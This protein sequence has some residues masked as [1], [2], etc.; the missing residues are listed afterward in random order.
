MATLRRLSLLALG[1]ALLHLIFGAIVRI[2][3]AGMGCGDHWP[4]CHGQWFPSMSDPLLVIEW[5]HRLLAALLIASLVALALAAW[6]RR[7]D[8][9]VGGRGG[10]LRAAGTALGLVVTTAAFGAVTVKL[11]N[12]P[13]ATV[14]HWG[15]AAATLAALAAAV[16]RAGGLGGAAA[17]SA[18]V[19]AKAY[20][21]AAAGVALALLVVLLGGLTAKVPGANIA[22]IGFPHCRETAMGGAPLHLQLTHRVLAFLLIF[23]VIGLF[24]A[25]RKRGELGGAPG[26]AAKVLLALVLAQLL[27]AAG[28]VESGLPPVVRSLHQAL[29]VLIW[30]AMFTLAYLSRIA[31]GIGAAA[32]VGGQPWGPPPERHDNAAASASRHGGARPH[33]A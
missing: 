24:M 19:S 17:R 22:C 14:V 32:P 10:V 20:R 23:H 8:A 25:M 9:G 27:V 26:R 4:K 2:T 1:V 15:L 21:G 12:A 6:R 5:T 31:A 11:G 30:L 13:V 18:P 28:M 16:M 29:G 33:E 7:A 3:G